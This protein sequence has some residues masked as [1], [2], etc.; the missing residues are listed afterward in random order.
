M[1]VNGRLKDGEDKDPN[2]F[3]VVLFTV[4]EN[5]RS[6]RLIKFVHANVPNPQ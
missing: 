2:V 5:L 3:Y 6:G 4:A 1:L